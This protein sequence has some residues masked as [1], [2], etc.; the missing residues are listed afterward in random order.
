[1]KIAQNRKQ[2]FTEKARVVLESMHTFFKTHG[3][4]AGMLQRITAFAVVLFVYALPVLTVL[5]DCNPKEAFCSPVDG[6]L[7]TLLIKI[8]NAVIFILFPIIVLMIVYTGFLFVSAQGN[9]TKIEEARRALM[10]T[11]IGALVLLGSKA[12]AMAI[13]ATVKDIAPG[14]VPAGTC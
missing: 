12:L 7:Y 5:A 3:M 13:C 2:Y 6:D 1:M 9:P 11:V 10:W 8:L 4:T 14:S